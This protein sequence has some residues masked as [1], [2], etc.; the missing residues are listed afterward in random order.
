MSE[1]SIRR[2]P[3]VYKVE[4]DNNIVKFNNYNNIEWENLVNIVRNNWSF[5][6]FPFN[7][8][9]LTVVQ[10]YIKNLRI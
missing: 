1:S 6:T 8:T 7:N 10:Q 9:E 2:K 3:F 4:S 5:G